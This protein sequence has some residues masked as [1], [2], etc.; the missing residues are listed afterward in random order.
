VPQFKVL[1]DNVKLAEDQELR[2]NLTIQRAVLDVLADVDTR[3]DSVSAF[4]RKF[5]P[6][7]KG[8][9]ATILDLQQPDF[10]RLRELDAG[11]DR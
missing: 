11:F 10:G 4:V 7:T 1:L 9:I 5:G 2:L 6:E 3:G 8:L